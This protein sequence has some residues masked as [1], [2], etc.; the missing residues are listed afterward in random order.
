MMTKHLQTLMRVFEEPEAFQ[1]VQILNNPSAATLWAD[2]ENIWDNALQEITSAFDGVDRKALMF[3]L[4][5]HIVNRWGFSLPKPQLLNAIQNLG[6][7]VEV[8]S[9]AGWL[10]HCLQNKGIDV[11]ATDINPW[12]H[13]HTDILS[14]AA[15]QAVKSH[16]TRTVLMSWPS[17]DGKWPKIMLDAMAGGQKL[18]LISEGRGGCCAN[19][20]F[21]DTLH[22]GFQRLGVFP[23]ATHPWAGI[24]DM[25][26]IWQKHS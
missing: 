1:I 5:E 10:T 21:F 14:L 23:K 2:D 20:D 3:A 11:I 22:N 4:R 8:G 7:I 9:G 15:D 17:L 13:P 19:G 26:E 18:V 6:P 24:N 12:D 16:P 25:T